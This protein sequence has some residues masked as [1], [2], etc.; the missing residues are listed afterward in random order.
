MYLELNLP[1]ESYLRVVGNH[2]IL[3]LCVTLPENF[4]KTCALSLVTGNFAR[5]QEQA[6]GEAATMGGFGGGL[7]CAT[8]P[9]LS[10]VA[11]MARTVSGPPELLLA[12][13]IH[14]MRL[15]HQPQPQN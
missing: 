3:S 14:S 11:G 7:V 10:A 8:R 5:D 6:A 2:A 13:G 1:S 4:D 9:G 15:H 12:P